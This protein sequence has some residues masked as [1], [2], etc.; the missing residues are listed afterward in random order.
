MFHFLL[1]FIHTKQLPYLY[2]TKTMH[3]KLSHHLKASRFK[4]KEKT[5]QKKIAFQTR[6]TFLSKTS[7]KMYFLELNLT[8]RICFHLVDSLNGFVCIPLATCMHKSCTNYR[9]LSA[10]NYLVCTTTLKNYQKCLQLE[11]FLLFSYA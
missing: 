10:N 2:T 8:S 3:A 5:K 1:Y 4:S 11:K 6:K 7:N 9:L